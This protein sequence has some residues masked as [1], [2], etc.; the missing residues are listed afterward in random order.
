MSSEPLRVGVLL[1]PSVQ[2]LDLSPIDLFGM[3]TKEHLLACQLPSPITALGIPVEIT[4]IAEAGPKELAECTANAG[5][6]INAGLKDATCAP[7]KLDI[8]MIPG[9]D[10]AAQPSENV[11]KFIRAHAAS[12][13][14]ILTVCTGVFP[15]AYSGILE[16]RRATGPR[17]LLPRLRKQFP[18]TSW[19]DKRWEVD[20]NLWSSG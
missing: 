3:C 5:L 18:G 19:M 6:R 1:L 17:P 7:D 2:L 14:D 4:Y 12:K 20:G 8:L 16:G 13:T 15:A 11:K 10:P 9:P